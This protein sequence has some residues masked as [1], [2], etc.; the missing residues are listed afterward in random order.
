MQNCIYGGHIGNAVHYEQDFEKAT[1]CKLFPY[2]FQE[3]YDHNRHC[4]TEIA[5]NLFI[6]NYLIL[7][8]LYIFIKLKL[9]QVLSIFV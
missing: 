6:I 3:K 1:D 4:I 7:C 2:L 5:S 9:S 8:L